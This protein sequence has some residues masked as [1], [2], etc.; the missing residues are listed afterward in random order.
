MVLVCDSRILF[1]KAIF[2]FNRY[3]MSQSHYM[4]LSA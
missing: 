2:V 3:A 4:Y 1:D